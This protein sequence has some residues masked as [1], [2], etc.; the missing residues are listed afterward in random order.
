MIGS[1]LERPR[2]QLVTAQH[3]LRAHAVQIVG[4][5]SQYLTAP[6]GEPNQP[7]FCNQALEI[8]SA[9]E[10]LDLLGVI[11]DIENEMGRRRLSRWGP[12][13]IDIDI[14]LYGDRVMNDPRLQVPHP[15]LP[16]R[17]FALLPLAEIAGDR[18]HPL[19]GKSIAT[20]LSEC[21]DQLSVRRLG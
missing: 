5:S 19:T 12:R 3:Q 8:R 17:R 16:D 7:D 1:N 9:L 11:H 4:C 6:W 2:E 15:G 18:V 21:T 13:I 14:L 10:P 20:M